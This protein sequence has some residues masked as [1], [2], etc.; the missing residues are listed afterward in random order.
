[1]TYNSESEGLPRIYS[2]VRA[3]FGQNILDERQT[4]T[5]TNT[6]IGYICSGV[7]ASVRSTGY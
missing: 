1:M 5:R 4:R 3:F 7:K 2:R 6:H